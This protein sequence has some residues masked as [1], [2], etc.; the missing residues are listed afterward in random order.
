MPLR[1]HLLLVLLPIVLH[2]CIAYRGIYLRGMRAWSQSPRRDGEGLSRL[3]NTITNWPDS[4][5]SK[6]TSTTSHGL[7]QEEIERTEIRFV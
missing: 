7:E 5:Y 1:K 6:F 2:R 4:G 3:H